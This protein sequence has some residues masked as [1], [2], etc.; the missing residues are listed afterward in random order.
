M[1]CK[2][3]NIIDLMR[4]IIFLNIIHN[5]SC[6]GLPMERGGLLKGGHGGSGANA[7]GAADYYKATN[8]GEGN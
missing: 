4:T 7:S 6:R 3:A 8:L 5:A 2:S 1:S